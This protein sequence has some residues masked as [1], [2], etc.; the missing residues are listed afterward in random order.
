MSLTVLAVGASVLV[1]DRGRAGWA[2][3]GVPRAGALDA[4]AAGLAN[5]LVGNGEDAAC[6]E[7]LLGGLAMHTDRGRWC[8][9]T[10]A[11]AGVRVDGRPQEFAAAVW[12]PAGTTLE[13]GTPGAGLRSYVAVAGGV[14]VDPV[15]GSRSTDT[16]AWVG[17]PPVT[18][19]DVLPV[20]VAA[21]PPAALDTPRT[22]SAGPLRLA[23]GPR[24]DRVDGDAVALLCGTSYTVSPDSDRIGLRLDGAPLPLARTDELPS[25]GMVLG[26]VQVPPDGRP[27]VFLADHPTTGGY[28]VV[29]VV[30]EADL[31][32]CAQLRP[33]EPVRFTR[34]STG[35][36]TG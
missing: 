1:Q 5:R 33:G 20:G 7:V 26:A 24:A 16:L 14:A 22:P 17:P 32:Q 23:P 34:S 29:A 2:H 19:G 28:P 8:A 30:D 25:E 15:L 35:R 27:V 6:L 36:P 13:V 10:G 21:G 9:V 31:W 18:V 12:W 11:V 4:P 3:L